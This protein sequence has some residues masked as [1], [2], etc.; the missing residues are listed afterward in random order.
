MN[1]GFPSTKNIIEAEK[2]KRVKQGKKVIYIWRKKK[3]KFFDFDILLFFKFL[4]T[5]EN[6]F[7]DTSLKP[8]MI[9]IENFPKGLYYYCVFFLL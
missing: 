2:Q 3:R 9:Y 4:L 5:K 1:N 8:A 6:F 7:S